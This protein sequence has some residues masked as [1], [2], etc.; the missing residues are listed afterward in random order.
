MG[1][2]SENRVPA[3]ALIV[4]VGP[5]ACGKSFLAAQLAEA[6]SGLVVSSDRIREEAFGDRSVQGDPRL[7]HHAAHSLVELRLSA[8][9]SVMVDATNLTHRKGLV[10][11]ADRYAAPKVALLFTTS[12]EVCSAR[13]R[14]RPVP[15]PEKVMRKMFARHR[16]VTVRALR[17]EG[18]DMVFT[19]SGTDRGLPIDLMPSG[20]DRS[21]LS[22]PFDVVGDIHGQLGMFTALAA[23]LGYAQDFT[24]PEGRMLVSV[25]DVVDRGPD[26]VR[27][28]LL[29]AGLVN[30]GV[31]LVVRG[32]HEQKLAR[33]L[34]K[35]L[36]VSDPGTVLRR[37]EFGDKKSGAPAQ[38][39]ANGL[40]ATLKELVA[41]YSPEVWATLRRCFN[42]WPSQ[43][44]LDGGRLVVAHGGMAEHVLGRPGRE[45]HRWTLYGHPTGEKGADGYPIRGPWQQEWSGTGFVVAG[46]A[47]VSEPLFCDAGGGSVDID[48]GAGVGGPLTAFRWP[49][50]EI[51]QVFPT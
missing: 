4:P 32:N 18:F 39:E 26:S 28:G 9:R 33:Y 3:G 16:S 8:A 46:H 10:E 20:V 37:L 51:V 30:R 44:I 24:H 5:P 12:H 50:R 17:R 47:V 40:T 36:K 49:E 48:T 6:E 2:V 34:G 15:V 22:G 23:K 1:A 27:T 29:V 43:M 41:D 38:G 21:V 14:V 19:V 25:G 13:N 42:R 7:V 45:S 35:M 31:M 11:L